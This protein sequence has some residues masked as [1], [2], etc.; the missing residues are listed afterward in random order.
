MLA[1]RGFGNAESLLRQ[2]RDRL[3]MVIG[4]AHVGAHL[5]AEKKPRAVDLR[6]ADGYCGC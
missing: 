3:P 2:V 6:H 5:L 4:H 1:V